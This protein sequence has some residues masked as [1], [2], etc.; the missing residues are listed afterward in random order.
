MDTIECLDL[1]KLQ[2]TTLQCKLPMP[3][4]RVAAV[5]LPD[6]IMIMGGHNIKAQTGCYKLVNDQ[7]TKS[8]PFPLPLTQ[9]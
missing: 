8:L 3:L 2:W 7:V 1:L 9:I 4:T 5:S 6:G